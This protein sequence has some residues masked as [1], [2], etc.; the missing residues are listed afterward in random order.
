MATRIPTRR[1]VRPR[2]VIAL[3]AC[4]SLIPV[5][6]SY[7]SMLTARS[8]SSLGVRTVEWLRANGARGLVDRVET[9]YYTLNAPAKGGPAL[10]ALPHQAGLGSG[11]PVST[12][13]GSRT[14]TRRRRRRVI[15]R[16]APITPVIHPAL[17]GEGRWHRT[18]AGGGRQPPLL[19]TSFRPEPAY[20]RLVAGVAWIDQARTSIWLYPGIQEPAVTMSSRG[21]EEV[22]TDRR[23]HLLA[24]FNSAFKLADS[25]G[26]FASGGHTYATMKNGLATVLRYRDGRVGVVD[27]EGGAAVGRNVVYARQNLA[28]IVNH[29]RLNPNLSNGPEWG[30]TLGNSVMVWRSGIGIDRHGN[31]LYA[32]A[33]Y[34]TV[35]SLAE[36]LKRAGALRAMEM[37]INAYW[38]SFI[39]YRSPGG[40]D[41][42]NLLPDMQRSP[43][44]Y[45]TPDD[46][47][48]FA[49]YLK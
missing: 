4:L 47:D 22:P 36:I 28:L 16:P 18:F 27:W 6:I 31:L 30:A 32:A 40:H 17:P 21:P 42:A 1:R 45:L 35:H 25:G 34:M 9:L 14:R 8:N 7:G 29:G 38:P 10:H 12:G 15:V 33:D 39:T 26:G 44:R 24:T 5:L 37:D 11:V 23:H 13:V 20:P 41:P 46:R 19:I 49:V 3:A 43:Y 2:R 48:F